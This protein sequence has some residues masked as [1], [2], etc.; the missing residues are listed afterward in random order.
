MRSWVVS[1]TPFDAAGALDEDAFR[2]HLRRIA[3]AGAGAYVGSS[4]VG[5]GFT[6][7]DDERDRIFTIAAEELKGKTPIRAAGCEPRGLRDIG[8]YLD[9]AARA[10]LDAAHIFQLDNGHTG[11]PGVAEMEAFYTRAIERAELPV[12]I[13]SYPSMGYV[14]PLDLI[15]KLLDRFPRI[16]ALRAGGGDLAWLAEAIRR[17]RGRVEVYSAGIPAIP[18]SILLGADGFLSGEGNLVPGLTARLCAAA[19]ANDLKAVQRAYR[20]LL[21][22]SNVLARFGASSGRGIKP[23]LDRLGLPGGTIRPPRLAIEGATLD[24]LAEAV[25]E[26]GLEELQKTGG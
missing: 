10:G 11:K 22:L 5:E 26:L 7:T 1:I 14:V 13:S 15:A 4:N 17:F 16:V 23:L 21:A 3:S 8:A 24:A 20:S 6:L 2:R 19:D 18:P 12:V 25:R 9:A